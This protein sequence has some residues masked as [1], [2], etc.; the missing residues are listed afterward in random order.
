MTGSVCCLTGELTRPPAQVSSQ[1]SCPPVRIG[2]SIGCFPFLPCKHAHFYGGGAVH[3]TTGVGPCMQPF[4][5]QD[6]MHMPPTPTPTHFFRTLKHHPH[7]TATPRP[8][9][10]THAFPNSTVRNGCVPATPSFFMVLCLVSIITS[11]I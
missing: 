2:C 7:V 4:G 5:C 6:Y 8:S 1:A 9:R 10:I 11:N 3:I